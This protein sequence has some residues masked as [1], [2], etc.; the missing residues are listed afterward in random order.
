[1]EEIDCEVSTR[2]SELKGLT[3]RLPDLAVLSD[4]VALKSEP[5]NVIRL[6]STLALLE[7]S[8]KWTFIAPRTGKP[9]TLTLFSTPEL[10]DEQGFL[11]KDNTC[12]NKLFSQLNSTIAHFS[13]FYTA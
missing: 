6:Y 8:S 2:M 7:S 4:T 13:L 1:M 12:W 10:G 9:V 3:M 5:I 11:V